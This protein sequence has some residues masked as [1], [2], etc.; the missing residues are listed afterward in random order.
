MGGVAGH[1]GL[2]SNALDLA[3]LM[4]MHLQGG[5]YGGYRFLQPGTVGLFTAQQYDSNRRGLGWDKPATAQWYGPASRFTSG[6]AFGH[7]GFTGT[8]AWADPKFNLVY[9]FL[10]NRIHPDAGNR[11]LIQNNIR[12][13]IQEVIYK[14]IWSYTQYDQGVD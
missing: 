4:Q 6:K 1:A 5:T 12:T 11:K 14:A 10:S 3:K 7:T 13:R 9:V 2:F 8:A